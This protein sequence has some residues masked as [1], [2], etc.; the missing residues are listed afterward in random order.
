MRVQSS[1]RGQE[2]A[3][4]RTGHASMSLPQDAGLR[5][6][7]VAGL[8]C[9]QGIAVRTRIEGRACSGAGGKSK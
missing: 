1:C 8:S 5:A 4:Q 3:E 2:G 7:R 9:G 6:D